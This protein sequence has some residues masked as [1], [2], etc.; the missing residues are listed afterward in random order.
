[1][2]ESVEQL[3]WPEDDSLDSIARPAVFQ[4]ALKWDLLPLVLES[5]ADLV[6]VPL[7]PNFTPSFLDSSHKT[8]KQPQRQLKH[9]AVCL[10]TLVCHHK[11]FYFEVLAVGPNF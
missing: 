1:M 2:A 3:K 4:K 5:L 11:L 8:F 10:A 7:S 9:F 6:M